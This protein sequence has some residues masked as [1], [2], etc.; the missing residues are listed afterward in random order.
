MSSLKSIPASLSRASARPA[1]LGLVPPAPAP[2][3]RILVATPDGATRAALSQSL[4][5]DARVES[6]EVGGVAEL[7]EAIRASRPDL[8]FFEAEL[9][10]LSGFDVLAALDPAERPSTIFLTSEPKDAARAFEADAAD[11]VVRP[12]GASRIAEALSR[13]RSRRAASSRAP[14]RRLEEWLLVKKEG[15][16]VFVSV[17]DLDWIGSARH[18]EIL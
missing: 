15:R 10:D 1:P 8:L 5:E 16:S 17:A 12:F 7:V 4:P 3:L 13:A 6:P 2:S 9:P 18:Q 11:C 14:S